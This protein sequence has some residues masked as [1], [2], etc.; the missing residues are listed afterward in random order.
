MSIFNAYQSNL[1]IIST[2]SPIN[3]SF[4][5]FLANARL[6]GFYAV[7]PVALVYICEAV[8][9]GCTVGSRQAEHESHRESLKRTIW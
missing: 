5:L 8:L 4:K 2:S 9:P 1:I 3:G 7:L 6:D